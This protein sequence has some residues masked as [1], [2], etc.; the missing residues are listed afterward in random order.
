[1]KGIGFITATRNGWLS[2]LAVVVLN[3]LVL[4]VFAAAAGA[5][6]AFGT[7]LVQQ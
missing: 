3:A 4:A 7:Q 1:M 5:G 6:L 2:W